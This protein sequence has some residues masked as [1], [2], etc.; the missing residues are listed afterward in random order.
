M[1]TR[2]C[3]DWSGTCILAALLAAAV[4]SPVR[5]QGTA[6]Q[7][8]IGDWFDPDNWTAGVPDAGTSALINN[9]GTAEI[10]ADA[11]AASLLVG[12]FQGGGVDHRAG[13]L[14]V[15][16]TSGL[17]LVVGY[18]EGGRGTYNL[19]GTGQISAYH[20]CIGHSGTAEFFQHAGTNSVQTDLCLAW[21][22]IG[23][24]SYYLGAGT[25]ETVNEYVG[26]DPNAD[27]SLTTCTAELTQ[28]GGTHIVSGQLVVGGSRGS[29]GTVNLNDGDL[30]SGQAVVGN[31]GKGAFN[32]LG[33]R[34]T[35]AGDLVIA[36]QDHTEGTYALS[37][38][39]LQTD[40]TLVGTQPDSTAVFVHSGG[41]H[42]TR[43]LDVGESLS[44]CRARYE[45]T[46]G[47]LNAGTIWVIN[48]IVS[49][50]G[51]ST[52]L[53]GTIGVSRNAHYELL[54]GRVQ[55]DTVHVEG[56]AFSQEGGEVTVQGRIR[57]IEG[58]YAISAGTLTV[59]EVMI[60]T[61]YG[62]S[63]SVRSPQAEVTVTDS[64]EFRQSGALQAVPG[65]RIH[66]LGASFQNLSQYPFLLAELV[67]LEMIF[68]GGGHVVST[69]EAAGAD[70]GGFVE[71]FA[72][73]CLTVGGSDVGNVQLVDTS[74]NLPGTQSE[75]LYLLG[76]GIGVGS[77]LDLNALK[78]YVGGDVEALLDGYIGGGNTGRLFDGTLAGAQYLDAVYDPVNDWTTVVVIPE[79]ATLA[80]F[81]AATVFMTSRRRRLPAALEAAKQAQHGPAEPPLPVSGG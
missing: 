53:A 63:F 23:S 56:G 78:P 33:G 5:A 38:G 42:T 76:L 21:G 81:A 77:S 24:A 3:C 41:L 18:T 73:G 60:G 80:L 7:G 44:H 22:G 29:A 40:Q 45:M 68:E 9:E 75:C 28:D 34:H 46:G 52:V 65:S 27:I 71:N 48:A 69:F 25:L 15:H 50:S 51:E 66:M 57:G 58:A 62:G 59:A 43:Y 30:H 67:N 12:L 70:G 36:N 55:V 14:T 74:D 35:V 64:L 13:R 47:E 19:S 49:Q 72:L 8:T 37:A 10:A 79:P 4:T 2:R 61:T 26:G 11:D 32:Q 31:F 54:H 16:A 39:E 17:A 20:E 6:W 1:K